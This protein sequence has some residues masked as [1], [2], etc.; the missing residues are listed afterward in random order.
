MKRNLVVHINTS[1]CLFI[2][3]KHTRL[4]AIALPDA[5][6]TGHQHICR[7]RTGALPSPAQKIFKVTFQNI[8]LCKLE[9]I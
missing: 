5:K 2:L 6:R 1:S 9:A 8:E 3:T 7:A 4:K